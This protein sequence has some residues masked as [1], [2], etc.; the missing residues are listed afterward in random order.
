MWEGGIRV[1]FLAQWKGVLPAGKTYDRPVSS[2]DILPTALAA[3]GTSGLGGQ[4]L[5]GVDLV[6]FLTGKKSGDPHEM[7]FWRMTERDIRAV[8]DGSHKLVKQAQKPNLFNLANDVR[9]AKDL[10]GKLPEVRDRL[11]KAYDEWAATLPK[12]LWRIYKT[13]EIEAAQEQRR[14]RDKAGN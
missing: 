12:P 8:R 10:D 5:D 14:K 6:P 13:P 9:E 11:Q 7:L 2:L 1:P 4:P 3:A